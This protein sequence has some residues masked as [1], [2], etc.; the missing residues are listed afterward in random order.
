MKKKTTPSR[1]TFERLTQKLKTELENHPHR[2]EVATLA[3]SQL[4]DYDSDFHSHETSQF[5]HGW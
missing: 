2:E 4:L 1:K 5:Q 3:L